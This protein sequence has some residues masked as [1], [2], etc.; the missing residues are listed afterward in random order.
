[1]LKSLLKVCVRSAFDWV[2]FTVT[3]TRE[4]WRML[5]ELQRDPGVP[6]TS[7]PPM[8]PAPAPA[9]RATVEC[10]LH[11]GT[12]ADPYACLLYGCRVENASPTPAAPAHCESCPF[13]GGCATGGCV[14]ADLS[15]P[16]AA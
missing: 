13:V 11:P 7:P 5:G 12:C 8:P 4:L 2:V 14:G 15:Q 6:D 1:M 10:L 16:D 9:A 3:D